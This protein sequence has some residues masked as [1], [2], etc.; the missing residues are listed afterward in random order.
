MA[1]DYNQFKLKNKMTPAPSRDWAVYI[2][3]CR[4]G[5]L[6]TGI[7]NNVQRRLNQH[8]KGKG[9]KYTKTRYPVKLR[10]Y[11]EGFTKSEALKIEYKIKQLPS[12][13]KV[14]F[15]FS[16]KWFDNEQVQEVW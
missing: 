1:I 8:N 13:A 11:V 15:L 3:E 7:T 10:G 5:T 14:H 6:Y 9:C 16:R 12:I 4:D 2:V